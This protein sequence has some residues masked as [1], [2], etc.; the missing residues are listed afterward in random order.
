MPGMMITV[1]GTRDAMMHT[2]SMTIITAAG[3][4]RRKMITNS[5]ITGRAA[6]TNMTK[7]IMM[8]VKDIT[9]EQMRAMMKR[10]LKMMITRHPAGGTYRIVARP[11]VALV[12]EGKI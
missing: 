10:I 7:M 1:A 8:K 12:A 9:G 5:K 11:A 6:A 2:M 3:M 4:K